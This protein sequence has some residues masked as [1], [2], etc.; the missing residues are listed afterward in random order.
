MHDTFASVAD[1]AY[2]AH[3]EAR[4]AHWNTLA[5][6]HDPRKGFGGCYRRRLTEIYRYLVAPG[7]RIA[8]FGCG[9]GDLLAA[10]NPSHGV[11]IDFASDALAK[12]REL[13]PDL[14]FIEHD[15][16]DQATD[17]TFDVIILSDLI[18]ELWNV[19]TVF[20]QV[21]RRS[22]PRTRIIMN[23]YSRLWELPLRVAEGMRLAT[24]TLQQNWLD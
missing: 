7:Q 1:P 14:Q 3:E 4:I 24:P 19:Q 20:D 10:L 22:H 23:Y 13:H 17:E 16:H 21:R 5:R 6:D 12:G 8:E 15:V 18:N 11:G 9:Q 2:Q